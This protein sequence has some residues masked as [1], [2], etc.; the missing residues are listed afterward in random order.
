MLILGSCLV[1]GDG[2]YG[3]MDEVQVVVVL[4]SVDWIVVVVGIQGVE[5]KFVV[6]MCEIKDVI[7]DEGESY[8]YMGIFIKNLMFDVWVVIGILVVM[9]VI[10]VWVMVVKGVLVNWV[11]KVNCSFV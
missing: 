4:C 6:F 9:F 11:V 10:V 5:S 3:L 1:L 7:E 8:G 2:V